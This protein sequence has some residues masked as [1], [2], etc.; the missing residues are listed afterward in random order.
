M[1]IQFGKPILPPWIGLLII[2]F[3]V[4]LVLV[5]RYDVKFDIKFVGSVCCK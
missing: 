1:D 4:N 5:L 3:G 2:K